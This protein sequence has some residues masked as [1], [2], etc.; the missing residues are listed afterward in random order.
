MRL[1]S[2]RGIAS[3]NDGLKDLRPLRGALSRV[4]DP[5][6][7]SG[8]NSSYGSVPLPVSERNRNSV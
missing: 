6:V 1:Y 2:N 3:T 8:W 5:V 4:L 7:G